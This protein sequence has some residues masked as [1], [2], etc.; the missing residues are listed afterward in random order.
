MAIREDR[1][2]PPKLEPL[3]CSFCGKSQRDVAKLVAGPAV[4]ICNEC[5]EICTDILDQDII[6]EPGARAGPSEVSSVTEAKSALMPVRCAL[7]ATL[8]PIEHSVPFPD[9]GWLCLPCVD[10]VRIHLEGPAVPQS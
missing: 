3:R 8:S 7:C 2:E 6:L 10:V 4:Q 9:R 5:V 1:S